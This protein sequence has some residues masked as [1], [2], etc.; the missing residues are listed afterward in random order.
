MK[1]WLEKQKD[2]FSIKYVDSPKK[3][4]KKKKKESSYILH[5]DKFSVMKVTIMYI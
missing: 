4:K 3:K 1:Y 5:R 2:V